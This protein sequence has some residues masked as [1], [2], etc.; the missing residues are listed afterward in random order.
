MTPFQLSFGDLLSRHLAGIDGFI[1]LSI[2]PCHWLSD[3]GSHLRVGDGNARY[4]S[5]KQPADSQ[6]LA[7]NSLAGSLTTYPEMH[8]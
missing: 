5:E 4:P 2:L 8:T 1:S 3:G 7:G 6:S